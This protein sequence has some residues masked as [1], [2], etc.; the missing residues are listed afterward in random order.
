MAGPQCCAHPPTLNPSS[1]AGHVEKFG[2]LDSYV[3]GSPDSKLAILLVSDV[4]GY[5]APNL[6]GGYTLRGV[7]RKEAFRFVV[8]SLFRMVI[9]W[10]LADKIAAAG[11]YAVVPDFFYGD[12][13]A[14]DNAERPIQ[15][16]LKDHGPHKGFEDAKRVIEALNS[17]GVSAIGAVGFCWGAKVVV[18]LG[19]SSAFIKAAVLCHPS[20]VT[21][22]D[23]KE[24]KV[25]ISILGAEIDQMSPPALLKQFEEVLASK[26]EVD[27]FVKIFPKVAHGWT[28]RYDVE[29]EAAVKSAEE[30]H[31]N[32]MEWFAKYV[33]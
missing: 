8:I 2:G 1:G 32:L 10:K 25:P 17:K 15:V 4:Y 28:V 23:F 33:K 27:S 3:S 18:E 14:R 19:K 12:P 26:S 31:G 9:L 6:R 13:F 5:E 24:F 29:D 21:V 7:L 22:D 11:F 30:A 16:W 20:F